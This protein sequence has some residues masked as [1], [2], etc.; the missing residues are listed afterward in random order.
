MAD[1]ETLPYSSN[2]W[3]EEVKLLNMLCDS[4]PIH[5]LRYRK[6]I[7]LITLLQLIFGMI[8]LILEITAL[9][10][11]GKLEELHYYGIGSG[12]WA[13]L[14]YIASGCI[15]IV[16]AKERYPGYDLYFM[17]RYSLLISMVSSSVS[18]ITAYS[19]ILDFAFNLSNS[20]H[21]CVSGVDCNSTM[22]FTGFSFAFSLIVFICSVCQPVAAALSLGKLPP[23]DPLY[24][25]R[26]NYKPYKLKC[27]CNGSRILLNHSLLKKRKAR[28]VFG[29]N[30]SREHLYTQGK[31]GFND[32][33]T[34]RKN[35]AQF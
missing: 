7:F 21:P 18:A 22:S 24:L 1:W 23:P 17:G 34:E 28:S 9:I 13:G 31:T 20:G 4:M 30:W 33:H 14:I 5:N 16:A 11:S 15:G 35:R 8:L 32:D 3:R 19:L 25:L 26:A 29:S 2:I 12:I 6:T 27:F 10:T